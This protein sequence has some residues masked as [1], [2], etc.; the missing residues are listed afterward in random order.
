[1]ETSDS[2]GDKNI[3][4]KAVKAFPLLLRTSPWA[5]IIRATRLWTGRSSNEVING[6]LK[7]N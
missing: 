1:M 6:K 7:K 4:S 5:D 2:D 3:I